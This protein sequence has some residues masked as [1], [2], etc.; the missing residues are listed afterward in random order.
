MTNPV[1]TC[2]R[3]YERPLDTDNWRSHPY[4]C[5]F[6]SNHSGGCSW[7][8][9]KVADEAAARA[10]SIPLA[11]REVGTETFV[12]TVCGMIE[13]GELDDWLELI[14]STGHDRKRAKRGVRGFV[15]KFTGS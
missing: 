8:P 15:K 2:N 1:F 9:M 10:A 4:Y 12:L 14:L 11:E 13:D 6:L 3:V 5:Q 7:E